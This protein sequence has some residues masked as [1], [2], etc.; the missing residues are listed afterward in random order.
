MEQGYN[1]CMTEPEL[2]RVIQ[3]ATGQL[4]YGLPITSEVLRTGFGELAELTKTEA[5]KLDRDSILGYICAYTVK[6]TGHAEPMVREIL[7]AGGRWLDEVCEAIA[8]QESKP[9]T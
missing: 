9:A 5:G 1:Q 6:K 2:Q 3:Y 7:Q 8:R 4:S